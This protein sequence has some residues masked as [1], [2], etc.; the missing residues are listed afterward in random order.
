M[1]L[2][3]SELWKSLSNTLF[4]KIDDE[5]VAAFRRPG[6]ANSRLAT[7][8]PFDK[9]M[10]YFKF[11]LYTEAERQPHR[12]FELYRALGR[13][14]VGQP[15]S[16]KIRS[17]DINIDYLFALEEFLFLEPAIAGDRVK[18]VV[19]IG[20]GFGRTCHT[21]LTLA[22]QI[23]SYTIVDLAHV[24]ELS[25]RVLAEVIPDRVHKVRFVDA[26]DTATWRNLTA[27]LAIN[28]D[29]FQEMPPAA[30]DAYMQGLVAQCGQF[31]AKNPV[32]KYHPESVGIAVENLA[33][34]K[35]VFSLGYCRDVIDIFDDAALAKARKNYLLAYCPAPSWTVVA[36][37]PMSMFPYLHHALY[38]SP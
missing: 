33:K 19:E 26:A 37:R 30:I 8:D 18:S 17:C 4:A 34:F 23:E 12:F 11:M 24:L 27:D 29:S 13:V 14:D 20:A 38:R 10:R 22:D 36:E 1:A 25:R 28:I 7:W 31:Y 9:T 32:A 15:V 5:F 21:L 6:G 35:D 3:V 2:E 16:V